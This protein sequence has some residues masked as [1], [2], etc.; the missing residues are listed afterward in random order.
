MKIPATIFSWKE[1]ARRP[2]KCAGAISEIY[3]GPTTEEAPTAI[4]PIKRK[5]MNRPQAEMEAVP[6]AA[7]KYKAAIT[8]NTLL[9]PYFLAGTPA[10]REPNT[11]PI[12]LEE[13]VNPCQKE[14]S[15][16]IF[17]MIFSAP[18]ITAVSKPNKKPPR[19][20]ISAIRTGYES[21]LDCL[22]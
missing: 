11:V 5:R 16:H 22:L 1:P 2:R 7:K 19:A 21:M 12:R 14:L 17:S 6:I 3:I 10:I 9:R 20:A 4:P 8:I 15:D 18:E 13:T